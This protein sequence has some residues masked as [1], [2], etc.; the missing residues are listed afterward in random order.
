MVTVVGSGD[1][2]GSQSAT[3]TAANMD[4]AIAAIPDIVEFPDAVQVKK[5]DTSAGLA[6][7]ATSDPMATF[8]KS[9]HSSGSEPREVIVVPAA[10]VSASKATTLWLMCMNTLLAIVITEV[11][12]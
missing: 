5:R 9:T 10:G 1:K 11:L 6:Y 8:L 4:A 3:L 12:V 2:K 7:E